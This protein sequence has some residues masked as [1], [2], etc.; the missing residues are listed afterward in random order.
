MSIRELSQDG[1]PIQYGLPSAIGA[2]GTTLQIVDGMLSWQSIV[3]GNISVANNQ[4]ALT[5]L[6]DGQ[7][8]S[9]ANPCTTPGA[10]TVSGALNASSVAT[11]QLTAGSVSYPNSAGLA[12]QVLTSSGAGSAS[13]QTPAPSGGAVDSVTAGANISVTGSSANPVINLAA[14]VDTASVTT[15]SLTIGSTA[16][17]ATGYALPTSRAAQPGYVL[18]AGPSQTNTCMWEAQQVDGVQ[19]VGTSDSSGH[20]VV[21]T[22]SATAPLVGLSA[23]LQ[24]PGSLQTAPGSSISVGGHYSLPAADGLANQVLQTNGSGTVSWATGG[25]GGS[26]V[27][28]VTSGSP[29]TIVVG[30]TTD[31]PTVAL[32]DPLPLLNGIV[33]RQGSSVQV[34]MSYI[35]PSTGG[36]PGSIITSAGIGAEA[37]WAPP[38][39]AGVSTLTGT[40]NQVACSAASGNVTLSLPTNLQAPG[41]VT[42]GGLYTLPSTPPGEGQMIVAAPSGLCTWQTPGTVSGTANQIVASVAGTNT[43]LSL[44]AGLQ[45]PG[46]VQTAPGSTLSVGGRYSLPTSQAAFVGDVLTAQADGGTAWVSPSGAG[47]ASVSGTSN[48]ITASGS[49]NVTLS[50]P[51][52]VVAPGSVAAQSLSISGSDDDPIA[53]P[54]GQNDLSGY[55]YPS[56]TPAGAND[57]L[58]LDI[59]QTPP[60]LRFSSA[61]PAGVTNVTNSDGNLVVTAPVVGV[62]NVNLAS[63]VT[64]TS[65]ADTMQTNAGSFTLSS[66]SGATLVS[67]ASSAGQLLMT[68]GLD[69]KSLRLQRGSV[70]LTDSVS[71]AGVTLD[72][73]VTVT[74][75]TGSGSFYRLPVSNGSSG[76][77]LTA[78]PSGNCTWSSPSGVQS[79]TSGNG[80]IVV[81][82]PVGGSTALSVNSALTLATSL[83]VQGPDSSSVELSNGTIQVNPQAGSG[84]TFYRLPAANGLDGQVL[85]AAPGGICTWANGGGGGGV[86]ITSPLGSISIGGSTSS[87][88][89]DV[90]NFH[91]PDPAATDMYFAGAPGDTFSI[92][93]NAGATGVTKL[94]YLEFP[95]TTLLC[96][97][98]S[99]TFRSSD[100]I[101][102]GGLA[103]SG[104]QILG[105]IQTSHYIGAALQSTNP[106][107]VYLV[108]NGSTYYIAMLYLDGVTP[109]YGTHSYLFASDPRLVSVL[110]PTSGVAFYYQ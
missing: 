91:T 65:G 81:S 107:A 37:T 38:S 56:V 62:K 92:S 53:L 43:T 50:L 66:G 18:V 85:T 6:G 32:A 1:L 22:G 88:T 23:S 52:T 83:T 12:G 54:F 86:T 79:I 94:L 68:S 104:S 74:P 100:L 102:P 5:P 14:A 72:T 8:M 76:Q 42:V 31:N 25:G 11:S 55:A 73:S 33:L 57:T 41:T 77:V 13:W 3:G 93:L 40:A 35:L 58:V 24:L 80:S 19:S 71:S 106:M 46:G 10:L 95:T 109:M 9:I 96:S 15:N 110:G 64:L 108:V 26:G 45:L 27:Q 103:P 51:N 105:V 39:A 29:L 49:T 59:T 69:S 34:G 28:S 70:V 63:E 97:Y 48:Q 101:L 82:P 60:R 89:L 36:P 16:P 67:S 90:V 47:V 4:L 44:A 21:I 78:S 75:P 87:P 20:G 2:E 61:P 84:G 98:D 99:T 30:G 7:L 17:A